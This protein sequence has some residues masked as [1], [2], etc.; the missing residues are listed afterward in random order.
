MTNGVI[1]HLDNDSKI[2]N[3]SKDLFD[4]QGLGIDYITCETKEIF[5][6]AI[7]DNQ[8][9]IKAL[10]FDL[11]SEEPSADELQ[12]KDAQFLE[13]LQSSF[14]KYNIP[15]FIYSG[16]LQALENEFDNYGTVFTVDKD[17]GIQPVFD[18]IKMLLESGFIDVFCPGGILE[19]E[20]KEEL[21]NSFI[22]QFT[23]NDQIEEVIKSISKAAQEPEQ[24]SD[25]V[26]KIFKR[27][28]IK[29]LASDLLAPV[30][31]SKDKVHPIEHFYK[32]QSELPV[33]TGDIWKQQEK[34][35]AVLVMTPR[36]DFAVNKVENIILC[37]IESAPKFSMEAK[38]ENLLKEL[39][40]Y[41]ID[42]IH[43]KAKRYIPS[44]VF[45]PEG[46]MV[47]V[48]KHSTINKD[49]FVKDYTYIVTLSD[50]LTNEIIG[51]FAYYFL[52]TGITNINENEFEAIIKALNSENDND[53]E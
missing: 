39:R 32:R 12:K 40:K 17:Q 3:R 14:A 11:L 33:W 24:P 13:N 31:D 52:R 16:F 4:Q 49:Q 34:E 48:S 2:L 44:N 29:A 38:R 28:A 37:Q 36:C 27:I 1:L 47:N 18:K 51:K 42:N 25:R 20:I 10:I 9:S 7:A 50:D 35:E 43:G 53:Q 23:K 46:G 15:I 19:T 45:F 6:S 26:K 41:L 21:H 8:S 30:I 5:E 22:K